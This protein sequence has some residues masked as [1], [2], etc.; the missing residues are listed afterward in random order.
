MSIPSI[1]NKSRWNALLAG[2]TIAAVSG[3]F[4]PS[5]LAAT[6]VL[7]FD[8]GA[9]GG[10]VLTKSNGAID[11]TQWADWGLEKIFGRNNRTKQHAKFMTYDTIVAGGRDSDLETGSDWGTP[12]QGNVLII[13]EEDNKNKN[14]FAS[15]GVYTP[16]DEA[17]G[18]KVN[19]KFTDTVAFKSFSLLDIDDNGG[20]IRIKGFDADNQKVLDIN[21]DALIA[22]HKAVNGR[23]AAAAQGTSVTMNGVTLTQVGNTHGD[24]SLFRFDINEAYLAKVRFDYPGSGAIAGLE[25]SNGDEPEKVPEPS[26]M[27]GLLMLGFVGTRK[28]LKAQQSA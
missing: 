12:E 13:Q 3:A 5:A 18:G 24:N 20:G 16:D 8:K 4:V 28:Y 22:E 1:K 19:F 23:N 26:V 15:N 11:T 6:F 17:G 14:L 10:E 2:L 27:G 21:V 9:D 25:W 7:D